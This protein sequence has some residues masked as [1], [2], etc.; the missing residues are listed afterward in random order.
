LACSTTACTSSRPAVYDPDLGAAA[1]GNRRADLHQ[2]CQQSLWRGLL[3]G[4]DGFP[5]LLVYAPLTVFWFM[6][7]MNTVNWLDGLSGLVAGVTAI[8]SVVLAFT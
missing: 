2:A 5:W 8:L 1:I 7:M 6:G 4:E 3:F